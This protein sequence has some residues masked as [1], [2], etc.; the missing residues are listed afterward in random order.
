MIKN[1]V[2][3]FIIR[4]FPRVR[5][6]MVTMQDSIWLSTY[7]RKPLQEQKKALVLRDAIQV[8]ILA[9]ELQHRAKTSLNTL[10]LFVLR[11]SILGSET[12]KRQWATQKLF[13][14]V[15]Q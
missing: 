7:L 1:K 6:I 4:T 13:L 10:L 15:K 5:P 3:N 9:T 12:E 14:Q 2:E 8:V 11:V